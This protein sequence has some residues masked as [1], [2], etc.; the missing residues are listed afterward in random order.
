MWVKKDVVVILIFDKVNFR[1]EQTTISREHYIMI[2]VNSS[3]GHN[4]FEHV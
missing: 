3:R 4:N 2:K 1:A